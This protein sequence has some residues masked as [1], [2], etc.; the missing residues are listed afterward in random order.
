MDQV[1][2]GVRPAVLSAVIYLALTVV[3]G[4]D[5]IASL[6]TAVA[7]D[8]GDP[9]FTAAILR[10][11]ASHIPWTDAWYQ[12]P[13]FHPT[14]DALTLS[15]HLLGVSVVHAPLLWLSGNP[16]VAYNLTVLLSYVLC[17]LAMYALVWRLTHS[18][19]AAFL[20][21][22]AYAFAPYRVS[23]LPHVQILATFWMPV[24]LL[25]LHAY[26]EERHARWLVLFAVAWALQGASNGYALVYFTFFSGL[27]V[28][29][30]LAARGRW[31]ETAAVVLAAAVAL[32]TLVPILLRYVAAQRALGLSRN[33]GEVGAY[34]ADIAALL[35][36]S[37]GLT[38]WG[39]LRTACVPEGE[40]FAGVALMALCAAGV[41]VH[42]RTTDHHGGI[43]PLS[44]S[45]PVRLVVHR[46]ALIL[47]G[48]FAAVTLWTLVVGPWRLEVAWL[49]ASASAADKPASLAAFFLLV[50]GLSSAR[51]RGVIRRGSTPTFYALAALVCW[52]LTWG[53]FP[54]LFGEAVFYQAPYAWLLQLPGVDALRAPAR[55][56]MLVVLC[57]VVWMG[58]G[59]ARLLAARSRR[60]AAALVVVAALGLAADGWT[61]IRTAAV[62]PSAPV[63][64]LQGELAFVLP[65]DDAL[66]DIGAVYHAVIGGYRSV[67]GYSGYEPPHY[68]ALRTMSG[69]LD[70]RLFALIGTQ[71]PLHVLVAGPHP[72][73]RRFVERQPGARLV[74]NDDVAHYRLPA[75]A[76]SRARIVP[77]GMHL[78][79]QRLEASCA[80]ASTTLATDGDLTTHW[81]CGSQA[82]GH[83]ITADLGR[84]LTVGSVV[85]ALGSRG[86]EFPRHL[87][88][89][90]SPDGQ[91][92]ESAWE[93]SPAAAVLE[94]ALAAPRE[95]RAV[96]A[97][98]PRTARYVRLQQAGGQ[99]DAYW[100]IA[101]LEIWSGSN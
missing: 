15:E 62:P 3:M 63:G 100:S 49:R 87:V 8:P 36:A 66:M 91:A 72:H 16:L 17:G 83:G 81:W 90:T 46:V 10:W 11:N 27:W 35:C 13:I 1:S 32:A 95:T 65:M 86:A 38:F 28:A 34:S 55:F 7:S 52:V 24:A 18:G 26:A 97:F 59:F 12:F 89:E 29:W 19:P 37:P 101:E 70:D 77:S 42:R 88:I 39:W 43:D 20:A 40:L 41:A 9:L 4:R 33:I 60:T 47:A 67:N 93:G 25:G 64:A 54:R 50:G 51:F 80:A 82:D 48:L 94:A 79:V 96:I 14:R 5:V 44:P 30:F 84:P 31:R 57:L 45:A 2:N 78:D 73:L 68:A 98:A 22:L 71:T 23:Q 21:G 85:H 69:A 61:T 56:W 58:I 6:G 75:R 99:R 92:W 74:S 53:P 76:T